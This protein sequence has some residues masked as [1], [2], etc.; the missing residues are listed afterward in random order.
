MAQQASAVY[1]DNSGCMEWAT[2]GPGKYFNKRKHINIKHNFVISVVENEKVRL[3]PVRTADMKADFLT[4]PFSPLQ[5]ARA[6]ESLT[7]F[8]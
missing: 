4:K 5:L 7:L 2:S 3:A 8:V 1:Q 6:T